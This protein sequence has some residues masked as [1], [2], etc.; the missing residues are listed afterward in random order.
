LALLAEGAPHPPPRQ[1]QPSSVGKSWRAFGAALG[2]GSALVATPDPQA[3][4]V[5]CLRALATEDEARAVALGAELVRIAN[6][7][8]AGAGFC[9]RSLRPLEA[10]AAAAAACDLGLELAVGADAIL[11]AAAPAQ[12]MQTLGIEV[13]FAAG[14]G[15]WQALRAAARAVSITLGRTDDMEAAVAR[16]GVARLLGDVPVHPF[17]GA[18]ETPAFLDRSATMHELHAWL[19]AVARDPAI[20]PG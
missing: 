20:R 4:V 15:A 13:P 17:A 3:N 19:S 18:V 12:R 5:G 8:A 2:G 9:G 11:A 7:L 1:A 16:E 10:M 14:W 6:V